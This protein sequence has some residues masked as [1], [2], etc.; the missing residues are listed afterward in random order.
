MMWLLRPRTDVSGRFRNVDEFHKA[1]SLPSSVNLGYQSH[2]KQA[3]RF[4]LRG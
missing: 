2:P 4:R 3:A 1:L